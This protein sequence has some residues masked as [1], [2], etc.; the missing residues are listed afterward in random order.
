MPGQALGYQ[1]GN[2]AVRRL[3]ERAESLLGARFTHRGFD[4]AV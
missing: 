3:R 2:L 1:F 4:D